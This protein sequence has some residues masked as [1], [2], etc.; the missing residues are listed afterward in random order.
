[1]RGPRPGSLPP[2]A[3]N[4][5]ATGFESPSISAARN[6][7]GNG[8]QFSFICRSGP[9]TNCTT[10]ASTSGGRMNPGIVPAHIERRRHNELIDPQLARDSNRIV[11]LM[12]IML[13]RQELPRENRIAPPRFPLV[14]AT[15]LRMFSNA[16]LKI[17]LPP[18]LLV[19]RPASRRQARGV[20]KSS[21][22]ST[23]ACASNRRTVMLVESPV[24]IR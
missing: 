23:Y 8:S 13:E 20:M 5:P 4:S 6:S 19:K 18:V 2:G 3:R 10:R 24:L 17:A 14:A 22:E 7:S 21:P 9:G 16:M 12:R 1:M 11:D 15:S